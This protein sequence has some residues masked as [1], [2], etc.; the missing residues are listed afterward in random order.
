M[1]NIGNRLMEYTIKRYRRKTHVKQCYRYQRFGHI[2][3]K[4]KV[5]IKTAENAVEKPTKS[6]IA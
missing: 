3:F 5:N 4:A 6:E 1:N 2:A